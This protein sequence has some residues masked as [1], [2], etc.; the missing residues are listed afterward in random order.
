L[1]EAEGESG[2]S[3]MT[4]QGSRHQSGRVSG[5]ALEKSSPVDIVAEDVATVYAADDYMLQKAWHIETC[6]SWHAKKIAIE[7]ELVN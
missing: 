4:R 7:R 1:I 6:G 5:K 2:W 3:S